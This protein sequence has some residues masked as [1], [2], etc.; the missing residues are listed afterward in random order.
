MKI[1]T[2]LTRFWMKIHSVMIMSIHKLCLKN[3]IQICV[4]SDDF[5][6]PLDQNLIPRT[7]IIKQGLPNSIA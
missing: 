4:L 5:H 7:S 3:F 1:G 2:R 6:H